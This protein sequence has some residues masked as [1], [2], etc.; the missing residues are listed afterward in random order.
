MSNYINE[1]FTRLD[2]GQIREFFLHG[3]EACEAENQSYNIRLK[4]GS[5]PI[6][7]RLR[8]IYSDDRH[9][10]E[11]H[12]D[13]S[14]ALSSYESVYMEIGMKAGARILYQLLLEER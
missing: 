9:M 3:V 12:G 1:I 14:Q 7:K 13:L 6:Y 11:A 10:D 5:D 4:Q 2:L 8:N